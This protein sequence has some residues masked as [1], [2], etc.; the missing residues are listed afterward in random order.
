MTQVDSLTGRTV[1]RYR[2]LERIGGGGMGVV[3][4]AEDVELGRLVAL[5]FLPTETSQDPLALERFKREARAAS[6]LNHP[7]ICT[8]YEIGSQDGLSYIAMEHLEGSNLRSF[9]GS[10]LLPL[11]RLLEIAVDVADALDAAHSKGIVHRDLKPANVFITNRGHAKLLDFGLAKMTGT[12]PRHV[13]SL[14][15]STLTEDLITTPGTAMGTV[16]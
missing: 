1:S 14:D 5:K 7:N 9:L 6:T 16:A 15:P 13:V 12:G 8:I 2:V 11:E 4:K 3:Y 10:Q